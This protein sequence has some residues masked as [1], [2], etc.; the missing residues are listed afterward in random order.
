MRISGAAIISEMSDAIFQDQP[1]GFRAARRVVSLIALAAALITGLWWYIGRAGSTPLERWIGKQIVAA[2][3]LHITPRVVYSDLDYQ[4]P[5]TVVIDDLALLN[6]EERI[7]AVYRATLSLAE[8]PREGRPIQIRE[9]D[10]DRPILRFVADETGRM[11]GWSNFA[12]S[13]GPADSAASHTVPDAD[14]PR[15]SDLLVLRQASIRQ[16]RILYDAGPGHPAMILPGI[17]LFLATPPATTGD[18]WYECDGH[19]D[20]A[21]QMSLRFDTRVNINTGN[22]NLQSVRLDAAL[23]EATYNTMPPAVQRF[24][25]ERNIRGRLTLTAKGNVPLAHPLDTTIDVEADFAHVYFTLGETAWPAERIDLDVSM[26]DRRLRTFCEARL[27]GGTANIRT[28]LHLDGDRTFDAQWLATGIRLEETLRIAQGRTPKYSGRTNLQGNAQGTFGPVVTASGAGRVEI[29]EGVLI[30]LPILAELH[31][32]IGG[33]RPAPDGTTKGGADHAS[34]DF[35]ITPT[36]LDVT[37]IEVVS[38]LAA[39]KGSGRIYFD[40]RL[41]LLVNAGPLKRLEKL[42]GPIGSLLGTITDRVAPYQ[43][44]GV[45]GNPSVSVRPLGL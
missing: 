6:G 3:E 40:G 5:L 25:A 13:R 11:S 35:R 45:I 32:L 21:P 43:I 9:I 8:I 10:L 36:H 19:L 12:R 16:G 33:P 29:T 15:L 39:M 41:D 31:A 37:D 2:I 38:T 42:L 24:L 7:L 30:A 27:L 4:A 44:H 20:R 1:R 14:A 22:L 34:L 23:D 26:A 17:E 18:G 28:G